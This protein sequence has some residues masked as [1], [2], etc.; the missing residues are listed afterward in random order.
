MATIK[1]IAN[2]TG[3]G[4]AT[5][6]KYLN[7]G[8]VLDKNRVAIEKSISELGFTVNEFARGLKTNKS[9]TIGVV[10]PE[11]SLVFT[12]SIITI[13][14]DI[15]RQNGYGTIIC[16]CRTD[17][18]REKQAV[19]FLLNKRVDG[20]I[21][22][23]VSKNGRHLGPAL[24]K[25]IPIV[26]FD[27]MIHSLED[28]VSAVVINNAIV[29]YEAVKMLVDA[30]HK[31]IGIILGPSDIFTAIKRLEGYNRALI[32]S[33]ITPQKKFIVY[34][35]YSIQGGYDAMKILL[36]LNQISA[37]FVTNYDMTL[38]AVVCLNELNISLPNQLSF[39]GFDNLD[40]SQLVKP[41]LTMVSQPLVNIG[42]RVAE[43]LLNQFSGSLEKQ[44]VVLPATI[45]LGGSVGVLNSFHEFF[46]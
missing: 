4:L 36:G 10:I 27:R 25:N 40:L 32:E 21:N 42:E 28:K 30:G 41:K 8:N 9:H 19:T 18:V 7:G 33:G 37:V 11:L 22:M 38:G 12:T 43:I 2:K 13:I 44:T 31:N 45:Q 20:I 16:D 23:P 1:D 39:I 15:L 35:D 34:S 29:S 6:S 5:I 14:E 3:L 24:K 46:D 26:L 17:E